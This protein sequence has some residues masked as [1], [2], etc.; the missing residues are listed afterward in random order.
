MDLGIAGKVA[1]VSGGS[2]GMGRAAAEI[3]GREGCRVGV[4]GREPAGIDEAVGAINGGGGTAIGISADMAT[5]EGIAAAVEQTTAAFGSPD[6][7]VGLNNDFNFAYFDE[8]TDAR[9]AEVFETLTLSQI[10][11]ARAT[12][13]AMRR[14]KWGRFIHVGS[15]VAKEAQFKHPHIYHNTVRP[16]TAAF[17]RSLAQEVGPDGVTVNVLGPGWIRTPSFDWYTANQLGF[18]PEETDRWLAGEKAYPHTENRKFLDVPLR[19]AG[20]MEEFGSVIAFLASVPGGYVTGEWIAVD[21]G[22]HAFTF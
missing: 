14:K 3:L 9:F 15:G 22:Q 20:T 6:I 1:L 4:V 16:S 8:S 12:V 19:R 2:K 13:P 10:R 17:L 7:V 11:L 5:E 21:G 18:T